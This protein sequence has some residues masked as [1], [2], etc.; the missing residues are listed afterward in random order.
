V[1]DDSDADFTMVYDTDAVADNVLAPGEVLGVYPNPAAPGNAH[2][3]FRLPSGSVS[4]GI[5]DL[6]GRLVRQLAT[7][8]FAGG[9]RDLKWDGTDSN[10]KTVA[11]G[12]YFVRLR[13]SSGEHATKR[14]VYLQQ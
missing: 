10:G 2:V 6:S 1:S 13:S 11:T 7:G 12:I 4:M 8:T 5:Y 3:L 14:L 9:L